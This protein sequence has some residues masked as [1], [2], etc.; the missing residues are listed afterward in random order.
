MESATGPSVHERAAVIVAYVR[1]RL[2]L[3]V[4]FA[5]SRSA[6]PVIRATTARWSPVSSWRISSSTGSVVWHRTIRLTFRGAVANGPGNQPAR[7]PYRPI[8]VE[9]DFVEIPLAFFRVESGCR[10][11]PQASPAPPKIRVASA[12]NRPFFVLISRLLLRLLSGCRWATRVAPI[13]SPARS[14]NNWSAAAK[15]IPSRDSLPDGPATAHSVQLAG[16][17]LGCNACQQACC[18]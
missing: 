1:R 8:V 16:G 10:G 18:P 14:Q 11:C 4:Q 5:E 15:Q 9:T 2:I 6:A 3:P 17:M 13:N 12:Q 7:H